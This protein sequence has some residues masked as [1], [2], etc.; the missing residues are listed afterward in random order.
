MKLDK[1]G[2]LWVQKG[3]IR[4]GILPQHKAG[5]IK[6][7]WKEIVPPVALLEYDPVAQEVAKT[8]DNEKANQSRGTTPSDPFTDT[9]ARVA[10]ELKKPA[11]TEY[12]DGL[13]KKNATTKKPVDENDD[14][15][16]AEKPAPKP[17]TK[18]G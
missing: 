9:N 12:D 15:E 5:Y 14:P 10:T 6:A 18:K 13:I 1:D 16:P 2:R 7:G 11:P 8:G 3:T 4:T 17:S